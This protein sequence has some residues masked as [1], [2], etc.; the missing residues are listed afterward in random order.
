MYKVPLNNL[1]NIACPV[2]CIKITKGIDKVNYKNIPRT[3]YTPTLFH[4]GYPIPK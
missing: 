1:M 2:S 4:S 3:L